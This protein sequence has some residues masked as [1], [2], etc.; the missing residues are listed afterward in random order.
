MQGN[1]YQID[2]EPLINIPIPILPG[3]LKESI[4]ELVNQILNSKKSS[5]NEGTLALEQKIDKLFYKF[6][7]LT[8]DDIN[9]IEKSI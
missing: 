1:N 3:Q 8:N 9:V 7:G 6:Y 2:K 5:S 4:I